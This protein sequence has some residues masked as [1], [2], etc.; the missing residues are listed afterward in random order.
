MGYILGCWRGI[1]TEMKRDEDGERKK[2]KT[3]VYVVSQVVISIMGNENRS[4]IAEE[5]NAEGVESFCFL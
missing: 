4:K 5:A 3:G 1:D 2:T